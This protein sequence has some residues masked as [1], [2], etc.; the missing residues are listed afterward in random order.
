MRSA[1][2]R[3]GTP[4][5][6]VR[7]IMQAYERRGMDPRSTLRRV[8]FAPEEELLEPEGWVA[9]ELFEALSGQAM[10]ELDDEALG[11]FSRRL[12][13]GSYGMLLRASLTAPNLEVALRRWC[14]HHGLLTDDVRIEPGVEDAA[15]VVRIR[16]FRSLG[17]LREFCLVSLLR[18]LH[19]VA[20]WLADSRIALIGAKF[21][22]PAPAHA[23]AYGRMFG[24]ETSF[25]ASEAELR[26]DAAY[27]RLPVVRDDVSLRRMLRDPI[28][29]MARRYRNDR[30]LSQRISSFLM[31]NDGL[32]PDAEVIAARFNISVRSLQRHLRNEGTSLLTL[33]SKAR[34]VR[35]EAM[36]RRGDVPLKRVARVAGYGDESSFGRAFRRWT[37]QSPAEFRRNESSPAKVLPSDL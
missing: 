30:L 1:A 23:E 11:W 36:L 15:A 4:A 34:R 32:P 27:L 28:S 13:W 21:P 7:A 10:R 8:G 35:A 18:N 26:F 16:E 14:R 5:A 24:G 22:F 33:A 37:G 3:P 25:D 12:P 2:S 9:I 19:G 17:A 29:L 6:F 31:A 20:C